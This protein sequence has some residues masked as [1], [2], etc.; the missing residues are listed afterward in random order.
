[1]EGLLSSFRGKRRFLGE[2]HRNVIPDRI[3]PFA[4]VALQSGIIGQQLNGLL[5]NRTDEDGQKF[6]GNRHG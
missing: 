6:L 5:A 4:D 1:M 2:H 3:N